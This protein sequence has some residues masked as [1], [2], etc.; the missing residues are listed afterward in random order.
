MCLELLV[1]IVTV[2]FRLWC[3]NVDV[4][5]FLLFELFTACRVLYLCERLALY[6]YFIII[7][8]ITI[9]PFTA[10][11]ASPSLGKT[12][13]KSTNFD[14]S[15]AFPPFTWARERNFIKMVSNENRFVIGLSNI[16]F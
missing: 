1:V 4:G 5:V 2:V 16:L 9:N 6:E 8:V 15:N 3:L 13:N 11:L 14:I 7:N 10:M 12:T